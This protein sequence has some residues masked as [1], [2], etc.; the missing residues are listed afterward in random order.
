MVH[1]VYDRRGELRHIGFDIPLMIEDRRIAVIQ[2]GRDDII[3]ISVLIELVELR[4]AL[5]KQ[6]RF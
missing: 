2:V 1:G 6:A 4:E 3:E 5:R